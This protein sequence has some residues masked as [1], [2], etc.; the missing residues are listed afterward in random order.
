MTRHDVLEVLRRP[1]RTEIWRDLRKPVESW[2]YGPADSYA[3]VLVD[4][5]VFAVGSTR[6]E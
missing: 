3:I 6:I 1:Q 5:R 2:F 4:G